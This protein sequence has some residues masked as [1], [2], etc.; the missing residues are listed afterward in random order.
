[1]FL[2]LKCVDF[3]VYTRGKFT[4]P[5]SMWVVICFL[6]VLYFTNYVTPFYCILKIFLNFLIMDMIVSE[7]GVGNV[8]AWRQVPAEARGVPSSRAG[9]TGVCKLPVVN[10][11][12]WT[13]LLCKISKCS[14]PPS[15]L[16]RSW[17]RISECLQMKI[18]CVLGLGVYR[19]QQRVPGV[20]GEPRILWWGRPLIRIWVTGVNSHWF[21]W[22]MVGF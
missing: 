3:L 14:Q 1:M 6:K 5:R 18:S 12:N 19:Y 16:F 2:K 11:G 20:I 8:C 17:Y 15:H 7:S 21:R 10:I 4:K 9:V 13:W 22:V